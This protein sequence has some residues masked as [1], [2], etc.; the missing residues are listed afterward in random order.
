MA[1]DAVAKVI[2]IAQDANGYWMMSMETPEGKMHLLSWGGEDYD[3]EVGHAYN[4]DEIT[5]PADTEFRVSL[6]QVPVAAE[7][8]TKKPRPR[9]A[10]KPYQVIQGGKLVGTVK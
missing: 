8:L 7:P 3:H 2:H 5:L 4:P 9:K 10:K 6:D 1:R